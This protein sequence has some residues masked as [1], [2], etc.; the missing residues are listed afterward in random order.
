MDLGQ[1]IDQILENVR[2]EG[3]HDHPQRPRGEILLRLT[4]C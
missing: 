1:L 4:G 2:I 3:M